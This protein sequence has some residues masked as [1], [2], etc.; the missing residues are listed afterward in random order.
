MKRIF[1]F[2]WLISSLML[3]TR[4]QA[5]PVNTRLSEN[6]KSLQPIVVSQNASETTKQSVAAL[7]EYLGRI[8]SAKFETKV[9]DGKSGIVIGLA[10]DFP[11]LGLEKEFDATD[12]ARRE[13]YILRSTPNGVLLIG[14]TDAA[15][16]NAVWDFLYRLGYRQFFPGA[17]WEIIPKNLNLQVAVDAKEKPDY[18][19]RRIWFTY[20]TW[21]E[22]KL[23]MNDWNARNRMG[24]LGLNTG[25]SYGGIVHDNKAEFL[26]HPEWFASVNGE[27][28]L[29]QTPREIE[30]AKFDISNPEL[31]QAVV[32]HAL[33]YFEKNPDSDSISVDPSDGG[34]WGN[35]EAE[36]KLG[37]ISDRVTLLANEVADAVNQKFPGKLVGFYA[38]NFHSPPPSIRV[39][40]HV[41][42]SVATAF[43]SG[44]YTVDQLIE[45]WQKQGATIGMRE[46]Y[47][48]IH[49]DKDLPNKARA[50]RPE[51][52]T[53]TL[54][55]FY[56]N[57]ARYM[58]AESS[59]NWGPN[60][61]GYY[62]ASRIMWDLDEV[63]KVP[64]LIE[65]FL[66]KSFG[67]AKEP[68]REY[69]GLLN[70]IGGA[71]S[72]PLSDDYVG[73]M[74]R[75]LDAAYQ[76]TN[77]ANIRARLDDLAL[78][79]R[80]VE[81]YLEYSSSQKEARQAAYEKL[82][83]HAY[84][85]RDTHMLHSLAIYRTGLRDK[86]VAIPAEAKWQVAATSKAGAPLNPWKQDSLPSS[87]EIQAFIKSGI[88]NNKL[89]EFEPK[90]FSDN[91]LPARTLNLPSA[92]LASTPNLR[93]VQNFYVWTDKPGP[94][95]WK[96]TAGFYYQSRGS[97]KVLVFAADDVDA[98]VEGE[99][100]DAAPI[101]PKPLSMFEIPPDQQEHALS[102][103][104]PRAGLYRVQISDAMMGSRLSWP[105]GI[106]VVVKSALGETTRYVSRWTQY[107]YVPKGTKL[108]GGFAYGSGQVRDGSGKVVYEYPAK[109]TYFSIP[110]APGQDGK[111]WS[112]VSVSGQ[113][114]LMTVPPYLARSATELL[115]P[116]E[117][118][119]ADARKIRD[120]QM[121][122]PLHAMA[123]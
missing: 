14:A 90:S 113:I 85:I 39:H 104:F 60:G 63:K 88:A 29:P 20:G 7:A 68:M 97:A 114:G 48:I 21:A 105:E 123:Q 43:I 34:N 86:S 1:L 12:P 55:H 82:I 25:H 72:R 33:R 16:Q 100:D 58:N 11:A 101:A 81:L 19:T 91:L 38:Y 37:S 122:K 76:K 54:P 116:H 57:G 22:N 69:F 93:G 110:V 46:Y 51:Y 70:G 18:L 4:L 65:D 102:V 120:A 119:E 74:Y 79:A 95:E 6:G 59:D 10:K 67:P 30:G 23:R 115:L 121:S 96:A 42:V 106:P 64:A 66:E 89:L 73:R 78:Y 75:A 24:G 111:V 62:L 108:V 49:W 80:Y 3:S 56:N 87:E 9:T 52:L 27:R 26:A 50:A 99:D 36:Q 109:D 107:F 61:L 28:K 112:F 45:G 103:N 44:G 53:S 92:P 71:P 2:T 117:V 5:A 83:R 17:H 98:P 40:P 15:V 77:D 32:R 94:M 13:E 118:V 8:S 47:S 84:S 41:V 31:R 35:S